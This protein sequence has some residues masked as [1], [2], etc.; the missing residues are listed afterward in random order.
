M[1]VKTA[2]RDLSHL[3]MVIVEIFR[4]KKKSALK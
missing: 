3:G 2:I 1:K 4:G